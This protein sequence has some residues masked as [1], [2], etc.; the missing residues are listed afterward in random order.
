MTLRLRTAGNLCAAIDISVLT[1]AYERRN[2]GPK[3]SAK[4][5]MS[6]KKSSKQKNTRHHI[7]TPNGIAKKQNKKAKMRNQD[8]LGKLNDI[9]GLAGATTLFAREPKPLKQPTTEKET[10]KMVEDDVMALMAMKLSSTKAS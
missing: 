6:V 2:Q 4:E 9:T 8:L 10:E 5:K 1:G 3:I 7:S